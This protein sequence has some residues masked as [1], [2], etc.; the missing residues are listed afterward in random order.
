MLIKLIFNA[1]FY[2][3]FIL[4]TVGMAAFFTVPLVMARPWIAERKLMKIIRVLIRAYGCIVV[5]GLLFPFVRVVYQDFEK[6]RDRR[7]CVYVCNHRASSDGFLM[8]VFDVEAVQVVNNW[9]FKIPVLGWIARVAGYLSV[10]TLVFE[11]F[12]KRCSRLL[13]EGVSVIAFPEGT[14][15]M[16]RTVHQFN[17]A[18]FRV[19]QAARVPIVPICLS[20]NQRLPPKGSWLLEPGTV[21]IHKLP[22][23]EWEEFKDMTPF[24]LKNHVREIIQKEVDRLEAV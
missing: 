1:V 17:G 2:P 15:S 16:D 8:A 9:P 14:R 21:R 24:K 11:D 20:G 10:R 22:A 3:L 23:L 12:L 7:N 19:A 13:A 5:Y 4:V 6:D 18:V